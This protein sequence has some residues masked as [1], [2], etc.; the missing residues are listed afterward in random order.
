[1]TCSCPKC[2]A[3]IQVDHAQISGDETSHACPVCS[4]RFLLYTESFASRALRK[5]TEIYCAHCGGKPGSSISCRSCGAVFPDYIVLEAGQKRTRK[6]RE[7]VVVKEGGAP[8]LARRPAYVPGK[9]VSA[10]SKRAGAGLGRYRA[11]AIGVVILTVF[12]TAGVSGYRSYE[13]QRRYVK[14]YV[15]A[16]YGI[17]TGKDRCVKVRTRLVADWKAAL[18]S[19][20]N[21]VPRANAEEEASLVDIRGRAGEMMKKVDETPKKFAAAKEKL[22]VLQGIYLKLS[23]ATLT[24]PSGTPASFS[25]A[26]AQADADFK[27]AAQDLKGTLPEALSEELKVAMARHLGLR[28]L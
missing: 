18:D 26:T 13:T 23:A 8:K 19:G 20:H 12:A 10:P 2:Q 7:A 22:L 11:I 14:D 17:K 15:S 9:T 28:D 6:K 21:A 25:D 5:G 27:R 16:L 24:V 1:M 4:A 3:D